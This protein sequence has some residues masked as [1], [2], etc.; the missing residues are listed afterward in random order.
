[1]KMIDL[2]IHFKCHMLGC[3]GFEFAI[4]KYKLIVFDWVGCSNMGKRVIRR[5][6]FGCLFWEL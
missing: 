6:N 3:H 5:E 4:I 2:D 1:M